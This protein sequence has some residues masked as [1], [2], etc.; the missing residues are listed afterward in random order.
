M[1]EITE[2]LSIKEWAEEDR[3]REKMLQK[4]SSVLSDAELIAILIGSGNDEETAVQL[5]QRILYSV[6]NNLNKLAKLSIK[7]LTTDFKGIGEAKAVTICAAL[8]L[9]KRRGASRIFNQSKYVA[10]RM[11]ICPCKPN[12][13]T[14]PTKSYGSFSPIQPT[15]YEE[16]QN[17]SRW[18]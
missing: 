14:Y 15:E 18:Y 9:G 11:H 12:C 1:K 6:N 4:G 10:A 8:E 16:M 7:Q 2:K 3:P 5:S 13:E 17:Q